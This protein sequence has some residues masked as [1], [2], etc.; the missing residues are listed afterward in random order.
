MCRLSIVTVCYQAAKDLKQTMDSVLE[1]TDRDFEYIIQDGKSS[2]GT[3]ELVQIYR[4][5]FE[6][7]HIPISFVSEKDEGIYDAMNR[8][9]PRCRGEWVLFLNA[10]DCF[11]ESAVLEK[12]WSR[13]IPDDV[14]ILYGDTIEMEEYGDFLWQGNMDELNIRCSLC[15]QSVLIR[16]KWMQKNGYD[17]K[18]KIGADYDFFLKTRAAG[19]RFYPVNVIISKISKGGFSNQNER[20]RVMET[21]EIKEK[22]GLCSRRGAHYKWLCIQALF[23]QWM[24]DNLPPSWVT[25]AKCLRRKLRKG[26]KVI[27]R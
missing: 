6:H 12:I 26:N 4:D 14:D 22:Y 25:R 13:A 2:D 21:E 7:S 18:Y 15:H 23:K 17:L 8:A 16:T 10:G 11:A 27:Q 20:M 24:I 19:R 9:L 5:K 1:Q 3:V